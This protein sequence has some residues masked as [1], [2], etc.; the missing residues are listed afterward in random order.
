VRKEG[1]A[2]YVPEP[3]KSHNKAIGLY[4]EKDF[5]YTPE[6]DEY[7]CPGGKALT[8]AG[9][10]HKGGREM[11]TYVGV[12]VGRVRCE[13]L[14]T[15]STKEPRH[16][17]RWVHEAVLDDLRQRMRLHPEMDAA[18]QGTRRAS[19][20]HDQTLDGTGVFPYARDEQSEC[21]NQLSVLAY[22]LKRVMSIMG[23]RNC[24]INSDKHSDTCRSSSCSCLFP[25]APIS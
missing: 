5:T 8:A 1:I 4:T 16:I 20:W 22:N 18:S 7:R 19:L 2:C 15:K 24:S 10:V 9:S 6:P 11:K 17:Y 21:R 13:K 14:C 23:V 3:Q 25:C 12:A